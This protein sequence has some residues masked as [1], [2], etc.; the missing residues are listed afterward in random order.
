[1]PLPA[2]D[3]NWLMGKGVAFT[4]RLAALT[5]AE[6]VAL[7]QA[8][9]GRY[10]SAVNIETHF[11]IVGQEGLPLTKQGTLTPK[12]RKARALLADGS[13]TI[14]T[15]EEFLDRL[16]L[17][18]RSG[19]VHR[20]YTSAQ[21][22][23]L[24]RI[25]RPRLDNWLRH[26]LI[27]P[28]ETLHGLS[29]FDFQQVTSVRTLWDL[30]RAGVTSGR[31]RKS[32]EQLRRWLGDVEQPLA[33][34]ALIERDGR[35]MLRLEEGQLADT[36]GQLQFDFAADPP[37]IVVVESASATA[38]EWWERGCDAEEAG[39]LQEAAAAYRQALLAGRPT[40]QLCF[41]L[42][43]VLFA[44]DQKGQALERF[45]QAVELDCT[46][47]EAWNN[48]GNTLIE[49]DKGDEAVAAFLQALKLN[50]HYADAHYNLAD[51]LEDLGRLP[52]ARPHWQ[53]YL[54]LEPAGSWANYARR[55]LEHKPPRS[56]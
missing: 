43:N 44:L 6:A 52:E 53:T 22:C 47:A 54:R 46:F 19:G 31:I 20:R 12:L 24:L 34:L 16:D 17:A 26:E 45:R 13:L 38:E 25:P 33:Q 27:Q 21:L 28:V 48:L 4:G 40:P 42:G 35:L 30:T 2:M 55:R 36:K 15:E 29:F 18:G 51:T 32:L 9:G 3:A 7:I 11:L 37:P 10:I 14:L 1:M 56:G 41:N 5:R 39:R 49:L 8:Y 50:P 23:R